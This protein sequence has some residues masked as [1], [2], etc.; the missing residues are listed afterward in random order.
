MA[1]ATTHIAGN[2]SIRG[3]IELLVQNLRERMDRNRVYRITVR[4]LNSLSDRELADLGL[5]RSQ[6]RGIALEAANGN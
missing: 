4:E 2:G 6:I 3:R 5:A 1:F